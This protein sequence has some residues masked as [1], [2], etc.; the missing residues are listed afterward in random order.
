[1]ARFPFPLSDV[2][3]GEWC[4]RPPSA[5]QRLAARLLDEEV[6]RRARRLGLTRGEF[7]RTAAGTATAFMVLNHD[8][9]SVSTPRGSTGSTRARAAAR[10]T[11][12]IGCGPSRAA[13]APGGACGRTGRAR[14]GSS[15][16]CSLTARGSTAES[17]F[18]IAGF[19][20]SA[21]GETRKICP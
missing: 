9:S 3:N 15:W 12:S 14:D 19:P 1:M 17:A 18:R 4:P 2:S 10:S 21:I 13:S 16:R 20:A 6:A 7:L 8:A 11:G 5:K